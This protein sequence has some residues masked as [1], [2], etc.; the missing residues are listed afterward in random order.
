[1][2]YK[3]FA[4]SWMA[5][6]FLASNLQGAP[7]EGTLAESLTK[8][9][10]NHP[11][12]QAARANLRTVSEQL[13]Q[14]ES[15]R[16]P[17]INGTGDY[18]I[19]DLEYLHSQRINTL[20]PRPILSQVELVQPLYR[21]GKITADV[22]RVEN[23]LLGQRCRVAM[24]ERDV[25]LDAITAHMALWQTKA[26]F[27]MAA[28]SEKKLYDVVQATTARLKAMES[29]RTDL[30]QSQARLERALSS[31]M[32]LK[33]NID[34]AQAT[35]F[36]AVGEK[37]PEKLQ[38]GGI[39]PELPIN[40][41]ES[42]KQALA[43]NFDLLALIHELDAAGDA[44]DVAQSGLGPQ[45]NVVG[46]VGTFGSWSALD[47]DFGHYTTSRLLVRMNVP[48][49]DGG[50]VSSS[51]REAREQANVKDFQIKARQQEILEKTTIAWSQFQSLQERIKLINRQVEASATALEGMEAE[52]I[53]G[54]R[55]V[56][57]TLNAEQEL[58]DARTS[59][60]RAQT[61]A[62]VSAYSLK[63]VTGTLSAGYLLRGGEN[64]D[65]KGKERLDAVGKNAACLSAMEISR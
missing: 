18:G 19:Y 24:A 5:G 21:S 43:N 28:I 34:A 45:V 58:L 57:E 27:Q 46:Q 38:E 26:I 2:N 48:F 39:P 17:K 62:V 4:F 3:I 41:E 15:Q 10:R 6:P 42:Q 13:V 8:A 32:E 22:R 1:M 55:T 16:L 36:K 52:L 37:A 63:A 65:G 9:V 47:P 50:F 29:T 56:I 59:L 40:L 53:H 64:Q 20:E 12:L 54:A 31:R 14:A 51:T 25:L 35:Y 33:N 23:L 61:D 30:A 49:Y 11:T 60:L 7:I 44:I